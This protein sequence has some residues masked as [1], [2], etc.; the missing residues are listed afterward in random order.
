MFHRLRFRGFNDAIDGLSNTIMIAEFIK[1]DNNDSR[2]TVNGDIVKPISLSGYPDQFWTQ[3]QL[4]TYGAACLAGQGTHQ[5]FA[6][7]RWSAPGQYNASMNT[8][9]PPNWRFP[10]CHDCSGCGQADARGIFPSRS[11]H[12]NGT[13]HALGDGSVRFITNTVNLT[14]Y[15]ALGSASGEDVVNGNY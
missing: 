2:F 4:D 3:S 8:M 7:F 9:A 6:G 1:G 13:M 14:T 11:R 12:P 10:A 15:Q 5:S